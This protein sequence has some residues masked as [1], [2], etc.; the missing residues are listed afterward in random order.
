MQMQIQIG[1]VLVVV[2]CAVTWLRSSTGLETE[3]QMQINEKVEGI[4]VHNGVSNRKYYGICNAIC[5]RYLSV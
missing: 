2:C 3:M 1:M 4:V 5:V